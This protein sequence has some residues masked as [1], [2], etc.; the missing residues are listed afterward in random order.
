MTE[1]WRYSGVIIVV[2]L[3]RVI[4]LRPLGAPNADNHPLTC[5][6]ACGLSGVWAGANNSSITLEGSAVAEVIP[7]FSHPKD[8]SHP[9]PTSPEH[10]CGDAVLHGCCTVPGLSGMLM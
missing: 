1:F 3:K 7:A 8:L 2:P 5:S 4:N 6:A 10:R 9:T